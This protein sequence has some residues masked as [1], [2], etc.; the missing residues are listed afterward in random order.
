MKN[1]F[2][3]HEGWI[4]R[5]F[6]MVYVMLFSLIPTVF[7]SFSGYSTDRT[8]RFG[9]MWFVVLYLTGDWLRKTN[10][11]F[12]KKYAEVGV[13]IGASVCS[14][15]IYDYNKCKIFCNVRCGTIV[16]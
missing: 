8:N 9:V 2:Q 14:L 7:S 6:I 15:L 13:Y 1:P 16:Y 10:F 4:I 3:K 5:S 11:K 12:K